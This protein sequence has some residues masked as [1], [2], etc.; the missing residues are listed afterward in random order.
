MSLRDRILPDGTSRDGYVIRTHWVGSWQSQFEGLGRLLAHLAEVPRRI[1]APDDVGL[2]VVFLQRHRVEIG[3]KL[4]LERSGAKTSGHDIPSLRSRLR[5]IDDLWKASRNEFD[6]RQSAFLDVVNELDPRSDIFRYPEAIDGTPRKHL[7]V[8]L[9]ELAAAGDGFNVAVLELLESIATA[10]PLP[11]G[12]GEAAEVLKEI[13][14]VLRATEALDQLVDAQFEAFAEQRL[15]VER[16]RDRVGARGRVDSAEATAARERAT[17]AQ[18]RIGRIRPPLAAFRRK[19]VAAYGETEHADV[20]LQ[21]R[22]FQPDPF[23]FIDLSSLIAGAVRSGLTGESELIQRVQSDLKTAFE[24]QMEWFVGWYAQ[25]L[26]TILKSVGELWERSKGWDTPAA[27]QLHIELGA[28]GTR[29][30]GGQA[31]G[32]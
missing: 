29:L 1:V 23:P 14:A 16:V 28:I 7:Y 10:E 12:L 4:L 21:S 31:R 24:R 5:S 6:R 11:V 20:G 2:Y 27:R 22:P 3:L 26:R 18:E 13:D 17:E 9:E 25:I 8:D 15:R 32:W 19:L 30:G